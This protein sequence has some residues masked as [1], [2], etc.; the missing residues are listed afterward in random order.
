MELANYQH[1]LASI[2][3][4]IPRILV[5]SCEA[6][7]AQFLKMSSDIMISKG[8]PHTIIFK[9]KWFP[10]CIFRKGESKYHICKEVGYIFKT[11][12]YP[13][14]KDLRFSPRCQRFKS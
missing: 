9:N 5:N 13:S 8:G 11:A 6:M 7:A 3:S 4:I 14:G 2:I 12:S 10:C 1:N